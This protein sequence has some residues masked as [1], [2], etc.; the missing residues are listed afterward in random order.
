MGSR[1]AATETCYCIGQ[2]SG[3]SASVANG[4]NSQPATA[5]REVNTRMKVLHC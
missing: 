4:R 3:A 2:A 1:V 5:M